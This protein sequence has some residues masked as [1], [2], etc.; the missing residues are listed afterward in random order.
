MFKKLNATAV[1]DKTDG[2]ILS[3]TMSLPKPFKPMMVAKI[4]MFEMD[5][6]CTRAPDG[7]TYVKDFSMALEG[8]AMMQAFD[9]KIKRQITALY[10]ID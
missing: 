10:P 1:L 2:E 6:Q 3:F 4:N 7:R 9:Q 8:S 5:V